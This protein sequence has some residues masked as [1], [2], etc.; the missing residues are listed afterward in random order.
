MAPFGGAKLAILSGGAV[1]T[2]LRDAD[3][4]IPWPGFWDLPGGGREGGETP[5]DC[6]L[7]ETREEVGL[8]VPR[9][10]IVWE[11]RRPRPG[12]ETVFLVALWPGLGTDALRL[13]DEGQEA[14][15]MPIA[16]FLCREDAVPM[17]Q[18]DLA[19]Y[20]AAERG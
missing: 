14:R 12:G 4:A 5:R 15:L 17:F 7:R 18:T 2:L 3:P 16:E 19:A 13:G 20:L 8:I 11:R 6:A 9:A 10:A 1:V